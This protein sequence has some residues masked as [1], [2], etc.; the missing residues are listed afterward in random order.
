MDSSES[1]IFIDK[2]DLLKKFDCRNLNSFEVESYNDIDITLSMSLDSFLMF[3]QSRQL[4]VFYQFNYL[5]K[6]DYLITGSTIS[7][8]A[9]SVLF[10]SNQIHS[11]F[12][13]Y[14]N[15]LL[16][17]DDSVFTSDKAQE[18]FN[19][20]EHSLA[21]EIINYNHSLDE[22]YFSHPESVILFV[23]Y[24]GH[25]LGLEK[26]F[27][28]CPYSSSDEQL[29]E[30]LTSHEKLLAQAKSS[31]DDEIK[32]FRNSL[33]NDSEFIQCT[34]K[35]LR[36]EYIRRLWNDPCSNVR[37]LFHDSF[38][39]YSPDTPSTS[40]KTFIE[41]SYSEYRNLLRRGLI[42]SK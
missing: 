2:N 42:K 26:V 38:N 5:D 35:A 6:Y 27:F 37:A 15:S 9:P 19:S 3:A 8:F 39:D 18:Q 22:V 29:D 20:F 13:S 11:D 1:N 36:A 7:D 40:F 25:L 21:S 34:N 32:L 4:D 41:A 17:H 10:S 12:P 30:F 23:L 14:L 28:E 33:F 24:E 31:L 16:Y